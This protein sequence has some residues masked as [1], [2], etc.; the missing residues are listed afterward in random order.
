MCARTSVSVSARIPAGTHPSVSHSRRSHFHVCALEVLRASN[1]W[2]PCCLRNVQLQPR[3]RPTCLYVLPASNILIE[4]TL[5]FSEK[6]DSHCLEN[7]HTRR[8]D[9][10]RLDA[11]VGNCHFKEQPLCNYGTLSVRQFK[12]CWLD[13]Y[14]T[15]QSIS[16]FTRKLCRSDHRNSVL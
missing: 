7:E 8:R 1:T 5:S 10:Q 14:N 15:L 16:S 9:H 13:D 11:L 4:T 2:A 3:C 6:R 12:H